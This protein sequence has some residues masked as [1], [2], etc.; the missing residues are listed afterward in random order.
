MLLRSACGVR[1]LLQKD[2]QS[3]K[4]DVPVDAMSC[5]GEGIWR[6]HRDQLYKF[7]LS[8]LNRSRQY[9]VARNEQMF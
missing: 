5:H 4:Q 2:G 1:D 6:Q 7:Q 8:V 3:D 9:F